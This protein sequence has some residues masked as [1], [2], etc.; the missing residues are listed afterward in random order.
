MREAWQ[1]K[2]VKFGEQTGMVLGVC[3]DGARCDYDARRR[4]KPTGALIVRF[5]GCSQDQ[6]PQANACKV[7]AT[8]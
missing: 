7:I 2:L 3:D 1:G 4:F 6:Y 8:K 5:E